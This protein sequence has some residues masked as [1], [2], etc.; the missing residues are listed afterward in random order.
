M[1]VST[2]F[3]N[4]HNSSICTS[5]NHA[6][7]LMKIIGQFAKGKLDDL[8]F[9]LY[10]PFIMT[11]FLESVEISVDKFAAPNCIV[12]LYDTKNSIR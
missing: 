10:F 7:N 11:L 3:I 2:Q 8:K 1:Y 5:T 12:H 9:R 4:F 6:M